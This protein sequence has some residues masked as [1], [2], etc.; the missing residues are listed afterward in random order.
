[1]H[2]LLEG[3]DLPL[4]DG[5]VVHVIVDE[6]VAEE[7][8]VLAEEFP[9]AGDQGLSQFCEVSYSVFQLRLSLCLGGSGP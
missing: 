3:A 6:G 2:D 7:P 8:R 5:A 9:H 4:D 1:M